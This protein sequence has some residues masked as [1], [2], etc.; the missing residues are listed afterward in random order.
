MI[1]TPGPITYCTPRYDASPL[2]ELDEYVELD[3]SLQA[4][5]LSASG[6]QTGV[7]PLDPS[8]HQLGD[9]NFEESENDEQALLAS[10]N[11]EP[12]QVP[13]HSIESPVSHEH[14]RRNGFYLPSPS[15]AVDNYVMDT[16]TVEEQTGEFSAV[17]QAR[18]GECLVGDDATNREINA[19]YTTPNNL[20]LEEIN[21]AALTQAMKQARK[22]S[23]ELELCSVQLLSLLTYVQELPLEVDLCFKST[24][25]YQSIRPVADMVI[26]YIE[27]GEH[28]A[29][30]YIY[31][32]VMIGYFNT[33]PTIGVLNFSPKAL[34]DRSSFSQTMQN[35][36]YLDH[37]VK[38]LQIALAVYFKEELL[39]GNWTLWISTRCDNI[40]G[41][42]ER[43]RSSQNTRIST[44]SAT[45]NHQLDNLSQSIQILWNDKGMHLDQQSWQQFCTDLLRQLVD[46]AKNYS[47]D[48]QFEA[49]EILF[50]LV[51]DFSP[52]FKDSTINEEYT[53]GEHRASWLSESYNSGVRPWAE[54]VHQ[55]GAQLDDSPQTSFGPVNSTIHTLCERLVQTY[56]GFKGLSPETDNSNPFS[57]D[58]HRQRQ[59]LA[60]ENNAG[61]YLS[62]ALQIISVGLTPFLPKKRPE[63]TDIDSAR[64]IYEIERPT[65]ATTRQFSSGEKRSKVKHIVSDENALDEDASDEDNSGE[66]GSDEE[67]ELPA[68]AMALQFP[69]H[70]RSS[71]DS[72]GA[73]EESKLPT[74]IPI[75]GPFP[76]QTW[77]S[78]DNVD[79]PLLSPTSVEFRQS[80]S[81]S[82]R[83][84]VV[85][86]QEEALLEALR[87]KQAR[88]R[89]KIFEE[90]VTAESL[91]RIPERVGEENGLPA[92]LPM[93]GGLI[94]TDEESELLSIFPTTY[95]RPLQ[96]GRV[97]TINLSTDTDSGF[98]SGSTRSYKYGV[99]MSDSD[100][101]GIDL[102]KY[103]VT[104]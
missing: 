14:N 35:Q 10:N 38:V 81:L 94:E 100:I 64:E 31:N 55:L 17:D 39:A 90:H 1:A 83:F 28:F 70:R 36:E 103:V 66:D 54:R 99:T 67:N 92:I 77:S 23:V 102:S 56:W 50:R 8:T 104:G 61:G 95:L 52:S 58:R 69:L 20:T 19:P 29:A 72:I 86:K 7:E 65:F 16:D 34:S 37:E 82:S 80:S 96:N 40:V 57:T 91:P 88:M 71:F 15:S 76:E 97:E 33:R 89:E 60:K 6:S 87:Q 3:D 11:L 74:I 45:L 98:T 13:V 51:G 78:F 62:R 32:L 41:I 9:T 49:A 5:N 68:L 48:R 27:K 24:S 84:M 75:A 79:T 85:T 2:M 101:P 43:L 63:V 21:L 12:A 4:L 47:L 22:A 42:I 46:L 25:L 18:S 44:Y 93:A 53:Y 59:G 30:V 26:A 73:V